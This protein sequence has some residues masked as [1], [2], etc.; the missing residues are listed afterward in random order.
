MAVVKWLLR[1]PVVSVA[2]LALL[3]S[4]TAAGAAGRIRPHQHY[5]GVVN[6]EHVDAVVYVV[7][8]GPASLDRTGPPAG[9][10]TVSVERMRNGEGR[11]G[12][13]GSQIWAV[14]DKDGAHVVRFTR[15]R[16]PAA[17]PTTLQ[18]PC[19]GKG[20]VTFTACFARPPCGADARDDVVPVS[21][22]NIAD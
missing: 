8:P 1:N 4:P 20:T 19:E 10:Q 22:V 6:D 7:C 21:F 9:G 16:E 3:V 15:Y 12:S 2:L 14:F 18:L 17:I 11:T 13:I 5:A